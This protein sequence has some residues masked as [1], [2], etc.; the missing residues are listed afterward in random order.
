M[1]RFMQRIKIFWI[2][3]LTFFIIYYVVPI[4][5]QNYMANNEMFLFYKRS[6]MIILALA[7]ISLSILSIAL[8]EES[9]FFRILLVVNDICK[10]ICIGLM[11]LL[12]IIITI[13]SNSDKNS[14]GNQRR[15]FRCT[16]CGEVRNGITGLYMK[17]SGCP[18]G[19]AHYFIKE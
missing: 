6:I 17:T 1:K 2:M 12:F 16:K 3:Y 10:Y 5:L 4:I 9:K 11:V 13:A 8:S 19:G 18:R 15:R 7:F 14:G